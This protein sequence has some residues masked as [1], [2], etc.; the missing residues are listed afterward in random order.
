MSF[1]SAKADGGWRSD[2]NT[3]SLVGVQIPSGTNLSSLTQP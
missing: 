3:R 1:G 2:K